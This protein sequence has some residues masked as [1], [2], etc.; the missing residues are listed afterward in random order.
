MVV[1]LVLLLMLVVFGVFVLF[2]FAAFTVNLRA[3]V[4]AYLTQHLCGFFVNV[5]RHA[6]TTHC[7]FF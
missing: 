7:P 1:I 6:I 5:N 2:V 4:G 3:T